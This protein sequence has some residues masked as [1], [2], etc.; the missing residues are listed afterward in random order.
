MEE[1][2]GSI[3]FANSG[4]EGENTKETIFMKNVSIVLRE[5]FMNGS[6]N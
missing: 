4:I 6:I 1:R 5:N 3:G 2:A